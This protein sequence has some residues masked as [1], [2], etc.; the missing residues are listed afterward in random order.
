MR[1][2]GAGKV[3]C[4]ACVPTN[5]DEG[6]LMK[7]LILTAATLLLRVLESRIALFAQSRAPD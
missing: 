2:P 6:K 4:R 3:R 7:K 5:H 1:K